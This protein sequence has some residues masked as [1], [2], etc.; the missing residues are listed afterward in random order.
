MN[1]HKNPNNNDKNIKIIKILV[2]D[3]QPWAIIRIVKRA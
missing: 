3:V 1:L 2:Q